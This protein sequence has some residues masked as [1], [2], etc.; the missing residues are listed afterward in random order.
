MAPAGRGRSTVHYAAEREHAFPPICEL[1]RRALLEYKN[2]MIRTE[3]LDLQRTLV[4]RDALECD[5]TEVFGRTRYMKLPPCSGR[6]HSHAKVRWNT[7]N[8]VALRISCESGR[9]DTA[10]SSNFNSS[11]VPSLA[12]MSAISRS[13]SVESCAASH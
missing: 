5:E 1:E 2:D 7:L 11:R 9:S 12:K 6:R 10:A 3:Y 8:R 13:A 4:E